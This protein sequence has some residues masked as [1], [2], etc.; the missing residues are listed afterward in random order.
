MSPSWI[1]VTQAISSVG[2][3]LVAILGFGVVIFQLS[4]FKR[5][6]HAETHSRLYGEDYEAIKLFLAYPT[7]RPYFYENKAPE[8]GSSDYALA[9]TAAEMYCV[10]FEHIMLQMGNLPQEIQPA[11][12]AYIQTMYNS[13]PAI[14]QHFQD[15]K[16]WYSDRLKA[17]LSTPGPGAQPV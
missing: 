6:L 13:S 5:S 12:R 10:H 9:F 7:L 17:V 4:Q 1:D 3:L 15:N 11:W 8:A 2:G 14:R 16:G